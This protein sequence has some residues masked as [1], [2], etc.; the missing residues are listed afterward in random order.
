[1]HLHERLDASGQESVYA[2]G[3]S[4]AVEFEAQIRVRIGS[5]TG[6]S[7]LIKLADV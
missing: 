3:F 2:V 7:A 5:A 4:I 1:M 6:M